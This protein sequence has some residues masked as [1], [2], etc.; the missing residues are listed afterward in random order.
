[1]AQQDNTS[2]KD[3]ASLENAAK[4]DSP[5]EV[6]KPSWKY[7]FRKTIREFSKD[8][9]TDLAAA[10]TYYTV[11][12]L[13]PA[14]LAMVSILGLVG[15][16]ESTTNALLDFLETFAPADA[17]ALVSGPIEQL[18]S[19][20]AAGLALFV[21]IAGALWSASGYVGAFGR[22][23]NRIYEV[24]EGRPIWKL[25]P[26]Q[27]LVTLVAI[28]LVAG[29]LIM[30]VISGPIAETIGNYIGMGSEAVLIWN[31]AKW[32]VMVLFAIVIIALLYY[33]TPN[34]KQPKFRWMSMGAFLALIVMAIATLGFAFYVGNFGSYNATYGAIGG[35]I[36]LLLWIWLVNISLLF[37]AEFDA[38]VERGRELQA[39]IQAEHSIQLP[40]RDT[41]QMDKR[42]E[43]E[44]KDVEQGRALR[45]QHAGKDYDDDL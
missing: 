35:V 8:Q 20:Q 37:G 29:L 45:Q 36:V 19:S 4:P 39:G 7:I 14:L 2:G 6:T 1:M 26:L 21:G 23:M 9:C 24:E 11:L 44:V 41:T 13:F 30:L 38:E 15:Q 12:S 34:V 16:A 18:T 33:A 31:I 27:L 3:G 10:L 43:Q 28:L 42:A 40:P 17:V 25:R 5:T 32:P 22:S